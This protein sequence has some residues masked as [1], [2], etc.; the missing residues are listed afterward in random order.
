[1]STTAKPIGTTLSDALSFQ[2]NNWKST[3]Q[4][5]LS[6]LIGIG[7]YLAANPST[8]VTE[9]TGAWIALITGILKIVL[10]FMEKDA[11]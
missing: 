8:V 3:A 7:V 5:V 4:S 11:T 9:K 6:V 1:M 2:I 10:G